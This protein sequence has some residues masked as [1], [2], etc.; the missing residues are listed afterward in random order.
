MS[1]E[2]KWKRH[3]TFC[4]GADYQNKGAEAELDTA[5]FLLDYLDLALVGDY[6]IL[7]NYNIPRAGADLRE[8]DVL[9]ISA[10]GVF[11]IE[12]KDWPGLIVAHDDGW[13]RDG[14][15][16]GNVLYTLKRKSTLLHSRFFK[17]DGKF[18][19]LK[20]ANVTGV[21]VLKQ[22]TQYFK[23]K[24]NSDTR[25]IFDLNTQRL[26]T[27]VSSISPLLPYG[28]NSRIL[29]NDEI[30]QIRRG[31]YTEHERH[32]QMVGKYRLIK[33]SYEGDPFTVYDAEDTVLRRRVRLKRFEMPTNSPERMSQFENHY[34]RNLDAVSPLH[35]HGHILQTYDFLPS[36][37]EGPR[38]FYEATEPIDGRRL[39]EIMQAT[40]KQLSLPEQL[41]Y[42]EPLCQALHAAHTYKSPAGEDRAIYHR[43]VCPQAVFV[44]R[45]GTVKL[46]DFDFAKLRGKKTIFA[47]LGKR[48][49]IAEL[50]P[51]SPYLAPELEVNPSSASAA[52]DIYSLGVLWFHLASLPEQDPSFDAE[53]PA[54]AVARLPLSEEARALMGR[55]MA[56]APGKRP[57]TANE[58]LRGLRQLRENA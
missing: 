29:S 51:E 5:Q 23:N 40:R 6:R 22:G 54:K 58:V 16:Q 27:S 13:Y 11:L 50:D 24:S 37:K 31:I 17:R 3:V 10:L 44:A 49:S 42:L 14:V 25:G 56:Y 18:G 38:V 20:A 43:H 12:V 39:D 19:H 45:N 4:E 1:H 33:K 36:P 52:S 48:I 32:E 21:V 35:S 41:A 46:G 26:I 55:M 30:E 15:F 7:I 34:R 47:P 2:D 8:I 9:L 57:A 28:E 53:H